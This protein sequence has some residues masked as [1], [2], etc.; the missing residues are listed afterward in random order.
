MSGDKTKGIIKKFLRIILPATVY[1]IVTAGIVCGSVFGYYAGEAE[2]LYNLYK[3]APIE[4]YDGKGSD[5]IYFLAVDSADAILIESEG[6]FALVDAGEDLDDPKDFTNGAGSDA[7]VLEFLRSTAEREGK[8]RLEFVVGTHSHSDHIGALD[9]VINDADVEIGKAYLKEYR[10]QFMTENELV[11]DNQIC[12]DNVMNALET[13]EVPVSQFL[14]DGEARTTTLGNFDLTFFNTGYDTDGK[15][16]GEN[17]NSLGILLENRVNGKRVWLGGDI[18]NASG[19]EDEIAKE[20]KN[21]DLYKAGHHAY[22]GSSTFKLLNAFKPPITIIT[23]RSTWP[24]I[25]SLRR[26]TAYGSAYYFTADEGGIMA[27][28]GDEIK[29]YKGIG[30]I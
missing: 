10:E 2:R 8:V 7:E 15:L 28:I 1:C 16:R 20:V 21:V 25:F 3:P 17:D 22:A 5:K 19:D 13:K 18:N 26:L 11:W 12:Y 30:V 9:E 14:G 4:T 6:K 23:N 29:L 24:D 27:V